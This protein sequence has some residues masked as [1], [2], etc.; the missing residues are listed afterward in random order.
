MFMLDTNVVSEIRKIRFGLADK[1]VMQWADGVD[2]IDLIFVG[3]QRAGAGNGCSISLA[4]RST[5]RRYFPG[6]V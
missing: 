4:P 1:N 2:A 6:L 3:N 5:T